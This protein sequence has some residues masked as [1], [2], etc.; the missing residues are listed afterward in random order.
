[1]RAFS[2][3][4]IEGQIYQHII[5]INIVNFTTIGQH[6]THRII[7]SQ[8]IFEKILENVTLDT[9]SRKKKTP[10]TPHMK[11]AIYIFLVHF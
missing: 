9:S 3:R 1:M 2:T 5:F 7:P 6:S 10:L 11:S 8:F 4:L